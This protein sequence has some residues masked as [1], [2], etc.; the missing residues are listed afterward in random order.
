MGSAAVRV[1]TIPVTPD[2]TNRFSLEDSMDDGP[3]EGIGG[4]SADPDEGGG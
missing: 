1:A 4:C 3:G 2:V